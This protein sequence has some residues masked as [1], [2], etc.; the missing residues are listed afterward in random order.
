M[1]PKEDSRPYISDLEAV[2]EQALRNRDGSGM[3]WVCK[4]DSPRVLPRIRYN[5]SDWEV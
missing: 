3:N 5:L 4:G 1:V 2:L